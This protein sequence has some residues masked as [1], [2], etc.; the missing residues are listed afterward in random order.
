MNKKGFTIIEL[1]TVMGILVLLLLISV[2]I[3]KNISDKLNESLY[4]SKVSNVLSRG[5]EY[6]AG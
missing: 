4:Q 6:A 2:P 3:Y 1:L 5:E